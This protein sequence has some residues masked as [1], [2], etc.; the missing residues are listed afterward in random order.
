M[1]TDFFNV[2]VKN[3]RRKNLSSLSRYR[4]PGQSMGHGWVEGRVSEV[5]TSQYRYQEG[6]FPREGGG[7]TETPVE[8]Q[9]KEI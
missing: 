9:N 5:R 2:E 4:L 1:L 7:W 6:G 8:V 3:P